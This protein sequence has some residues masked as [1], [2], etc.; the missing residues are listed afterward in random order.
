VQF[1]ISRD[2]TGLVGCA[3]IEVFGGAVGLLRGVAVAQRARRAGLGAFLVSVLVAD[4]RLR[5]IDTLVV[6]T[7]V[8]AGYFSRLG[9]TPVDRAALPAELRDSREF[10]D[11]HTGDTPL[12]KAEL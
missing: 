1:H 8:A 11:A 6:G 7:K 10:A 12:L 4:V 2:K 5:G 3:G 9:F